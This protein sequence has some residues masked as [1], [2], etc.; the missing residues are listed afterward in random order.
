M[1]E[2]G[3]PAGVVNIVPGYGPIAGAA[4]VENP[5]VDRIAF[6]GST[7]VG[8]QIMRIA[9]DVPKPVSLELGGKSPNIIF[10][11][12]DLDAAAKGAILG[13]FYNKGETCTAGSRLFVEA[14]VLDQFA[15]LLGERAGKSKVGDPL[16]TTTKIGPLVSSAQLE[17]V[18]SYVKVGVE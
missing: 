11:D 15:G 7:D 8:R 5:D 6:T 3:L 18:E 13:I 12:A 1:A 16:D 10:A 2:A 17:K 4:L 14:S 9:S